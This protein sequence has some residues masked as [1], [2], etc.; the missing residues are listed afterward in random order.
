M[1]KLTFHRD[2]SYKK[3]YVKP[4][5]VIK[6]GPGVDPAKEPG[7]GF[8]GSTRVNPDQSGKFFKN[9]FKVLIFHKKKY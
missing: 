2:V 8:Y 7:L 9:I 1:E 3:Q 6:P 4:S 5:I